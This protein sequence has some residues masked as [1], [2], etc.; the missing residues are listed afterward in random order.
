MGQVWVGADSRLQAVIKHPSTNLLHFNF[1]WRFLRDSVA[2]SRQNEEAGP[3]ATRGETVCESRGPQSD[4]RTSAV[5][6]PPLRRAGEGFVKSACRVRR[7]EG[8]DPR[9]C[10]PL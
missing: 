10:Q 9:G 4:P 3:L 1:A 5:S 8:K 7:G 6:N 2:G